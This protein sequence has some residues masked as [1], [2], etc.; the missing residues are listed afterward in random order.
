MTT[1]KMPG[2]RPLAWLLAT[3]MVHLL[4]AWALTRLTRA[5]HD[6]SH[7][8]PPIGYGAALLVL[9]LPV[10]TLA[11]VAYTSKDAS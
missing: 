6:W 4:A 1:P 5:L 8:I 11:A 10:L 7:A 9:V 3:V 2:R